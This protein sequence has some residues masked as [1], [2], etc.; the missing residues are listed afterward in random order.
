MLRQPP[1]VLN[2][3]TIPRVRPRWQSGGRLFVECP[4]PL[5]TEYPPAQGFRPASPAGILLWHTK[6]RTSRPKYADSVRST[7]GAAGHRLVRPES[8]PRCHRVARSAV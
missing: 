6:V 3:G 8:C 4:E 2:Y 5:T 7:S 1:T